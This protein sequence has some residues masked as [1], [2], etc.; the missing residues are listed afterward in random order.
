M[1]RCK[2]R[3]IST[4]DGCSGESHDILLHK[5]FAELTTQ[6][7]N[8]SPERVLWAT[9]A[10]EPCRTSYPLWHIEK[11]IG[12]FLNKRHELPVTQKYFTDNNCES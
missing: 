10:G 8:S 2:S 9:L 5:Y 4:V 11:P 12:L 7:N 6:E 1:S 3:L